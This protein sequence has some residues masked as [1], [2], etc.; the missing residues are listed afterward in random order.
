MASLAIIDGFDQT[1]LAAW[2]LLGVATVAALHRVAAS[3]P[4]ADADDPRAWGLPDGILLGRDDRGWV[5]APPQVGALVIG[6]PRSGKTTGV[7]IPN[8]MAWR[9]P[10]I[11]TSTR[12]EVLDACAPIR[13]RRGEVWCFEPLRVAGELP[14]G[15]RRLDWTPLRGC[16]SADAAITRA[17]ALLG[18]TPRGIEGASHWQTRGAQLLAALL[19]AAAEADLR[20]S[21][22]VDWIHGHRL[23]VAERILADRGATRPVH[24]LAGIADTPDRERGSI[25]STV[26]ASLSAFDATAVLASAD[27]ATDRTFDPAHF[28]TADNTL[29]IIAPSDED[30]SL[31][32]LV[33]GLVE[34][35]RT[36]ALR[37]SDQ[38]GP[39][40]RPFLLALDEVAT[41]CPLPALPQIASE[42]GGRNILLLAALQ[43]LNQARDRWSDATA[44]SLLSLAGAKLC[45]SGIADAR[46]LRD[47]ETICGTQWVEH[48][49]SG[50]HDGGLL[51]SQWSRN[52]QRS[53]VEEPR[54]PAAAIRELPRGEALCVITGQP[55]RHL[56]L[57]DPLSTAPFARWR[58]R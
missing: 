40:E 38:H 2:T 49:S 42:G 16:R 41:I 6:P 39:L 7:V 24:V 35:V 36:A 30:H 3:V 32:P 47:L 58:R 10:V 34:E 25:W 33:V 20:M 11:T 45:L 26:S 27:A 54:W 46:T 22:V 31:A 48:R 55:A 14:A 15:V 53:L 56:S 28:L 57:V 18:A 37:L 4:P 1:R 29:L 8:V 13:R 43:D 44:D 52:R 21:D 51:S 50:E 5:A 17:R 23:D 12:R 19:Q 9:G